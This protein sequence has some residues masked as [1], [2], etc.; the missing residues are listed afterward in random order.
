M[1]V[2]PSQEQ[3]IFPSSPSLPSSGLF[4]SSPG[5][6]GS[7]PGLL[8]MFKGSTLTPLESRGA[9][10]EAW[11]GPA[12]LFCSAWGSPGQLFSYLQAFPQV[13]SVF[14]G[15]TGW[16]P[17]QP[18]FEDWESRWSPRSVPRPEVQHA[19][20]T[21]W[22]QSYKAR[23]QN[24]RPASLSRF[25]RFTEAAESPTLQLPLSPYTS[26]ILWILQLMLSSKHTQLWL[27]TSPLS[28]RSWN[29]KHALLNLLPSPQHNVSCLREWPYWAL[30]CSRG[31]F[32]KQ[33]SRSLLLPLPHHQ[34]LGLTD[35]PLT[36][37]SNL[38]Q[39]F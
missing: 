11:E 35:S 21:Q 10:P 25:L 38:M 16:K 15:Q 32:Q 29:T 6:S 28:S 7:E 17:L 20:F 34:L 31:K 30:T 5:S 24:H 2:C 26:E 39:I 12:E 37:L 4:L 33:F 27:W 13:P 9:S 1:S 36:L 18:D 19:G 8:C 22:C 23:L 3:Q 14:L